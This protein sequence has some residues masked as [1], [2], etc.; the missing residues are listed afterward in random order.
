M[1]K[2]NFHS[3]EG[4]RA[5]MA[6]WVVLGHAIGVFGMPTWLPESISKRIVTGTGVAVEVF[7]IVSGFVIAHLRATSRESYPLYIARRF[8]RIAPIYFFC[9]ALSILT[10]ACYRDMIAL[11]WVSMQQ[12]RFDRLLQTEAHWWAHIAAH[13][14]LLHGLIP[15]SVLKYSSS[16]FLSPAWSLSLEWQFYLVA[17]LLLAWMNR[18]TRLLAAMCALL[19]AAGWAARRWWGDDYQ[20]PSMLLLGI[21]Y[22][23]IGMVSRL[24][25]DRMAQLG[26]HILPAMGLLLIAALA[27]RNLALVIWVPF[28]AV[29][30]L[31]HAGRRGAAVTRLEWWIASNPLA[32]LMGKVSYSTYLIHIPL[33]SIVMYAWSQFQPLSSQSS[34]Q[35]AIGLAM[36]L[37]PFVSWALYQWV[38]KPFIAFGKKLSL[39]RLSANGSTVLPATQNRITETG[40]G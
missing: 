26:R 16:A 11:P 38:E 6:W 25:L 23:V 33:F 12:M 21:Q 2:Q 10:V 14:T 7:I 24:A 18:S 1:T 30:V 31:Q 32:R 17:P 3:I 5:Y 27:T 39:S 36:L 13:A 20:Y 40:A 28:L 4:L 29:I 8:L 35:A 19:L 37:L 22:F 9:I 15:E 34:Q